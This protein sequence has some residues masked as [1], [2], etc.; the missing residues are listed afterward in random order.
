MTTKK[1]TPTL[2]NGAAPAPA[3]K[4]VAAKKPTVKELVLPSTL[5][6][7]QLGDLMKVSP[8]EVIKQLM[9]NGVMAGINQVVDFD[10]AATVTGAFGF[11][12]KR[13]EKVVSTIA[14]VLADLERKDEA[15][16]K[17]RSPV[18]T[19]LG[20]VDHGKTTLLDTIRNSR[21]AAG[22]V[23]GITQHIGAYQVDYKD[24]KITFLDTPG[25]EAFTA[26]R[27]RG[28]SVTD[29]AVLVVAADDGVMPQTI[30]AMNHAKAANLPIIVAI[31]KMDKPEANPE[32]VKRQLLE[33]GLVIEE[34]G[35]EVIAVPL[36]AKKGTGI[37]DLLE[38]IL[39]V[40]EIAELKANFDRPATGVVIEAKLDRNKG[41]VATVLVQNGTLKIGDIVV[42]GTVTG[43]VKALSNDLGRRVK[44]AVP[45][46]PV[47]ILGYS[48]LP[49]AGDKFYVVS[50]ER[51]AR[52]VVEENTQRKDEEQVLARA[53]TLEGVVTRFSAGEI[54][55]LN[56]ILKADTQGSLEAVRGALERLDSP[57][58]RINILH[59]ASG[60]ITESDVLLASASKAVILGF[61]TSVETSAER[62]A[63]RE[64]VQIRSYNIIYQLIE[65]VEKA[66]KGILEPTE[67]DVLLGHATVRAVF[68][69]GKIG[70]AA[71]CIVTDGKLVRGASARVIRGGKIIHEGSI[72]TL[73]RFKDNVNEVATGFEC[74]VGISG[75]GDYREGDVLEV[76][77]KE[78]TRA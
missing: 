17:L 64:G 51:M 31:N 24:Q 65:D 10:L 20:H 7:K 58:V 70:K 1:R 32:K 39:V 44:D 38:N 43:K 60:G 6:V 21:V 25:H 29:I 73:R 34:L 53:M 50:E 72:D 8:V 19:I 37:D 22:E 69:A 16:L 33:H 54:K 14:S 2:E 42:A 71:G 27:A 9:R 28:A 26:I 66:L 13:E 55:E 3:P 56:L 61:S 36:S 78:R 40:S 62:A 52:D 30:E 47:E 76:H 5:T 35:G 63:E 23:G 11:K 48:A 57:T 46:A 12:A 15:D 75:F 49:Q 74:G 18:V 41:P 4:K 59:A 77:R 67:R 45:G 68:S